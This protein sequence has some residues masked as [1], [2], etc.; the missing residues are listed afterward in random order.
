MP[1]KDNIIMISKPKAG[2]YS[3]YLQ[4]DVGFNTTP[5]DIAVFEALAK[6]K[7]LDP[8]IDDIVME[9]TRSGNI[10]TYTRAPLKMILTRRIPLT[11]LTEDRLDDAMVQLNSIDMLLLHLV[12][13][14]V[15]QNG[16]K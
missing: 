13:K 3:G 4:L 6:R 7:Q 2:M 14:T 9:A 10:V 12:D 15:S 1:G 5:V 11:I 8:M 16:L